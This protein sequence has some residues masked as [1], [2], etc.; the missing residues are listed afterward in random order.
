MNKDE[1]DRQFDEAFDKAAFSSPNEF[2]TDYTPSWKKV[3]KQIRGMKKRRSR[4]KLFKNVSV[5][6]ASM[7]L[8]AM[9]FGNIS[10]TKAF[11]PFY[12]SLKE[13]PGEIST[14]FFGNQDKAAGDDAKTDP[15]TD[16]TSQ[17]QDLNV[18]ETKVISVTLEEAKEMV[19][20]ELPSFN[21]IPIGYEFKKTELFMLL[22]EGVS[23]KA[24][25]T[26]T[27][28]TQSFWVTLNTLA[29][30][31]N[32]GSGVSNTNIEE[33]Q[34]KYGKGYLSVSNDGSS[35][36]EFLKRNIYIIILGKLQK[37]DIIKIAEE[38]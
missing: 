1:L 13:L 14:L 29:D 26:F 2:T 4:K 5:I 3:K 25:F 7:L 21:Y 6:A 9:I 32:V 24:R 12:Q 18:G 11:N 22:G 28:Q 31:T 16:G 33:V 10:V 8:G 36:L 34:L 23:K 27:N 37:D 30:D 15:P 17:S 19:V 20:F 35:K 38:M